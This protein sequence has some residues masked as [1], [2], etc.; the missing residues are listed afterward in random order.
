MAYFNSGVI[1]LLCAVLPVIAGD[2]LHIDSLKQFSGDSVSEL[3]ELCV[4]AE[5]P[6]GYTASTKRLQADDF[7]GKYQD[8]TSL[9]NTVSGVTVQRTGGLGAYSTVQIRGSG[10][11]QVQIF[12]DGVPL[13]TANGGAVDIGKIPLGSLQEII[14]HK[15][16][17][18]LQLIGS[19][20]GGIIELWSRPGDALDV[21]NATGEVGSFGYRKAGTLISKKINN[22]Q[23]WFSADL[24]RSENDFPYDWD[25]SAYED[26]D[27]I[28]K[29]MDNHYFIG[30]SGI[31]GF[32]YK[33]PSS[34]LKITTQLSFKHTEN[35]IFL[36]ATA[37]SNDGFFRKDIIN[38]SL[39]I[40]YNIGSGT[41]LSI[42]VSGKKEDYLL[43][44]KSAYYLGSA[45]KTESSVPYAD[46][47]ATLMHT[48]REGFIGKAFMASEF[49]SYAEKDIWN[50]SKGTFYS[51]R[52]TGRAGAEAAFDLNDKYHASLKGVVRYELDST[53]G[54]RALFGDVSVKPV[55]TSGYF[56]AAEALLNIKLLDWLSFF[57]NINYRARSPG[58]SE[59]FASTEITRGNDKLRPEKRLEYDAGLMLNSKKVKMSITGYGSRI[60][61]K[62]VFIGRSQGIMIPENFD[63]V[64]G[65]GLEWECRIAVL[66]WLTLNNMLTLMKNTISS[67]KY[68][69]WDG[70]NEPFLPRFQDHCFIDVEFWKLNFRH[71][72]TFSSGY[73]TG[74]DNVSLDFFKPAPE[75]SLFVSLHSVGP[76]TLTYRLENY[77]NEKIYESSGKGK[78]VD[79]AQIY[80]GNP[81]PGRS[82]SLALQLS[83]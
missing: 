27:E 10:A 17:A 64:H 9:L 80:Y 52:L 31:Y 59:K 34:R 57:T 82:H 18:P 72:F 1:L 50:I 47:S 49:N 66:E 21:V 45:K 71:Q 40:L 12:L 35:G 74:P 3:E 53:N 38:G 23:H 70:K 8:L 44:R 83:F 22:I 73:Y 36:I 42:G 37:D 48:F 29:R 14:V 78:S 2:S 7:Q 41:D 20:A 63:D 43:Q 19:N 62:I 56:P 5:R 15:S 33:T 13:N 30:A 77:L 58:F 46:I 25:R 67:D 32:S 76:L 65:L 39:D 61:D 16:S 69:P 6:I 81:K 68:L 11:N 51:R 55:K 79:L 54:R 26:G 24:T 75:L 60:T 28:E 4:S